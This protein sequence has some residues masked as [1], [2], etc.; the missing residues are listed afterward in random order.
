FKFQSRSEISQK[1]AKAGFCVSGFQ[2]PR[3]CASPHPPVAAGEACV[4][5]RSSRKPAHPFLPN[6]RIL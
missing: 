4:R 5:L 3:N 1:P 2:K 6:D